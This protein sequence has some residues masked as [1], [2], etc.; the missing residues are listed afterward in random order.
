MI[1]A[2]RIFTIILLAFNG[3]SAVAGGGVLILDPT[4][5]TIGM[6]L[7]LLHH[8]PFKNFLLPGILLFVFDGFLSLLI[9]LA[10]I[11]EF[12]LYHFMISLQ[13]LV[14][15]IWIITQVIMIRAAVSLHY[16]YGGIGLA[17][18]LTGMILSRL[19]RHD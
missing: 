11:R 13:G 14:S 9:L 8:S 12:G 3:L 7:S 10:V 15:L 6:P 16:I 1:K 19:S 4:G 17:L 18:L 5:H 2:L